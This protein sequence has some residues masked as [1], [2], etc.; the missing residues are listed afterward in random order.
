M[1]GR[2]EGRAGCGRRC[3]VQGVVDIAKCKVRVHLR[4]CTVDT[5]Q[6][7][8]A[9]LQLLLHGSNLLCSWAAVQAGSKA[10]SA[11]LHGPELH[12]Q[13]LHHDL[14]I[15]SWTHCW[16]DQWTFLRPGSAIHA[17]YES[18]QTV[19]DFF[20]CPEVQEACMQTGNCPTH[21][22]KLED[23]VDWIALGHAGCCRPWRMMAVGRLCFC[24]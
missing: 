3:K 1:S 24:L 20:L 5:P 15:D 16:Q 18:G 8:E 7:A 12:L 2:L 17:Y 6:K 22:V 10:C 19:P 23:V 9:P 11:C 4:V 13:S 14:S 21:L